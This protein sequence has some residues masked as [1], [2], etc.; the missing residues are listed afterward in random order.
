M[1]LAQ[2]GMEPAVC[3]HHLGFSFALRSAP[4]FSDV[5]LTVNRGE[6]LV[7]VGANGAGK[8][9]LLNIIGGKRRPSRGI[10]TVLGHDSFDHTP[11]ALHV[12][13]VTAT[14]EEA[15]TLPVQPSA[16]PSCDLRS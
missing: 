4:V 16:V 14:W 8:T 2:K 11:L 7:L 5:N 12:N 13:I 3:L 10:A 9:T 15:L 6:R 1:Y